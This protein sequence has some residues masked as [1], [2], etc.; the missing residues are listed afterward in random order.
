M[1]ICPSPSPKPLKAPTRTRRDAPSSPPAQLYHISPGCSL[2]A[3]RSKG[4]H[5]IHLQH[6]AALASIT[7]HPAV[8]IPSREG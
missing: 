8:H 2:S 4:N 7:S 5:H 1:E 3:A 6:P